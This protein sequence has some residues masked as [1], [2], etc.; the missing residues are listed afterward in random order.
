MTPKLGPAVYRL[1][2]SRPL[3]DELR[4]GR[5]STHRVPITNSNAVPLRGTFDTLDLDSGRAR[6]LRPIGYLRVR[7]AD[8]AITV[9]PSV[10]P[11]DLF[12]VVPGDERVARAESSVAAE[13]LEVYPERLQGISN[14]EAEAEGV[15][16]YL[17]PLAKVGGYRLRHLYAYQAAF[18][19]LLGRMDHARVLGILRNAQY[20]EAMATGA[21]ARDCYSL[22]WDLEYG[23]TAAG[24]QSNP[25]VWVYR[26]RRRTGN[27]DTMLKRERSKRAK[28]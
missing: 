4:L 25:W 16:A 6:R 26:I 13:V 7:Q 22:A 12:Y 8:R 28:A 9:L 10:R 15:A 21:T 18:A 14:K 11:R 23:G 17:K 19:Y 3:Y 27:A 5:K 2:L 1:E 24:W 20:A